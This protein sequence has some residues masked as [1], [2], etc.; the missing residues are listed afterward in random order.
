MQVVIRATQSGQLK[1]EIHDERKPTSQ[2][3]KAADATD[4]FG[5]YHWKCFPEAGFRQ[6]CCVSDPVFIFWRSDG[7]AVTKPK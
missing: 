6:A 1:P 5:T 4:S 2:R 3:K 7:T